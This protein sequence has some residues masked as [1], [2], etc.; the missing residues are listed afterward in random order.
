MLDKSPTSQQHPLASASTPALRLKSFVSW[1]GWQLNLPRRWD[2]VKLEGD[3]SAGYALFAD[4]LRPRLGLR[5]SS[6]SKRKGSATA[7]VKSALVQEV[8]QLAADEAK[9]LHMPAGQ[10]GSSMLYIEPNPP[11]RD[12][13][14][15]LSETSGRLLQIA[16]HAHRR[17]HILAGM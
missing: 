14:I 9:V 15:G 16:Y 7:A 5:W 17:E 11:G 4:A 12:V 10:W 13:W 1:Q 2:P 6:P 3:H 8:G